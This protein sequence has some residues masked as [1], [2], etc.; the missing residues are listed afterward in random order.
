MVNDLGLV[1]L[2]AEATPAP[3]APKSEPVPAPA[4]VAP[5]AAPVVEK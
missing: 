4:P 5:P 2:A 1:A 3:V